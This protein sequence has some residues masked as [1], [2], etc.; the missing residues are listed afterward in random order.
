MPDYKVQLDVYNG[1]LDLLLYLIRR[2]ELDVYDIP[3]AEITKQY[4][5][6]VECL[7]QLDPDSAAEF[8][9]MATVLMEVKSRL[10]LPTPPA[11]E[12]ATEED[13][14]DPR[15]AL[16]RQLLEYKKYKDASIELTGVAKSHAARWPR[17]PLL[18]MAANPTEFELDDVQVWD[19]VSAFNQLMLSIGRNRATHDVVFDDTPI[20]LHAAD[21]QDRLSREGTLA[22][23][24]IF[25][26]RTKVEMIGLFLALLEL[27]RQKRIRVEQPE[28]AAGIFVVPISN[29]P[30]NVE[31]VYEYRTVADDDA[32]DDTV[33][34][35]AIA[36]TSEAAQAAPVPPVHLHE[37]DDA[38]DSDDS[39]LDGDD[40]LFSSLNDIKTDVEI[41]LGR[42]TPATTRPAKPAA[43]NDDEED[44]AR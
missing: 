22:F 8:V 4:C 2:N 6:Y 13:L 30:I 25:A 1:P 11:E 20:S 14:S 33:E 28:P 37:P 29:E 44:D 24:A 16:V 42:D 7:H 9:V 32:R 12:G 36:A 38:D 26:G 3:I 31:G 27:I 39:L 10:L 34:S 35:A 43:I 15:M 19:L 17:S 23:A 41:D 40:E 5:Q 18:P 21:I